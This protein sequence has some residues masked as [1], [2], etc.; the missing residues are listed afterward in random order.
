MFETLSC[1]TLQDWNYS[2]DIDVPTFSVSFFR[3]WRY[4]QEDNNQQDFPPYITIRMHID[5]VWNDKNHMITHRVRRLLWIPSE[6]SK[7]KNKMSFSSVEPLWCHRRELDSEP[8]SIW[9]EPLSNHWPQLFFFLGKNIIRHC[10][11]AQ[12]A[13][14]ARWA[15]PSPQSAP[16]AGERVP[17]HST[18]T[19]F[20]LKTFRH[21]LLGWPEAQYSP[22]N[23]TPTLKNIF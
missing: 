14:N 20:P 9:F 5:C 7:W 23:E 13:G 17:V 12:D 18:I 22:L 11:V 19:T 8:L 10:Y 15:E 21:F 2:R 16:R 4:R 3:F 1:P 6:L